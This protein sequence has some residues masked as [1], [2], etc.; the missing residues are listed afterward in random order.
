[1][2]QCTRDGRRCDIN[3]RQILCEGSHVCKDALIEVWHYQTD[4]VAAF[5]K[6]SGEYACANAEIQLR[7]GSNM[8][9]Q[10][11]ETTTD[12]LTS[13]TCS[14]INMF[15][16]E[17]MCSCGLEENMIFLLGNIF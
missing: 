14:V 11:E 1:M 8:T 5:L 12:D 3:G 10:S 17:N 6:C 7:T 16:S 2:V 9:C 4:D 13:S 15:F